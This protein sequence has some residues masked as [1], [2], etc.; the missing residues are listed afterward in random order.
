MHHLLL[1]LKNRA[2]AFFQLKPR[3]SRI[4]WLVTLTYCA[5]Y[6]S[7]PYT[8]GV[9]TNFAGW[10]TWIDQGEYLKASLAFANVDFLPQNFFYPP[11][12]PA[13]GSIFLPLSK[14]H[15]YFVINLVC[16]L[17]FSYTFIRLADCYLS[18]WSSVIILFIS[19]IFDFRIFENFTIPW[20]TT[21]NA[22]LLSTAILGL[23]WL[24]EI[25]QGKRS[26]LKSWEVFFVSTSLG[27]LVPTRPV[28]AP[29]GLILGLAFLMGYWKIFLS[30][31]NKV[32]SPFKFLLI[33]ISGAL[34]GPIIFIAFNYLVFGNPLGSYIQVANGAGIFPLDFFEKFISIWLDGKTLYGDSPTSLTENIPWLL[35]SIA[36]YLWVLFNG[37]FLLRTIAVAIAAM[38]FVYL[39][40]GDLL[41]TGIWRF[42]NIHYFKWILPYLGLFA[43]LLIQQIING[44]KHRRGWVLPT[45]TLL[46]SCLMTLSIQLSLETKTIT[47]TLTNRSIEFEIPSGEV[48]Y[49][50]IK[51]IF[52]GFDTIYF[53][54][55]KAFIDGKELKP[56][57]EF[58]LLPQ[59][60]DVRVLFIRPVSGKSLE[61]TPDQRMTIHQSAL[62]AEAGNYHFKLG[63]LKPLREDARPHLAAPYRI[64]ETIDFSNNRE[65]LFYA[66]EGFSDPE[67]YGRWSL[68]NRAVIR[69]HLSNLN[70]QKKIKLEMF[71]RSLIGISQPC[72]RIIVKA[73][74][75]RIG[76]ELL[77]AKND[78][79]EFLVHTYTIPANLITQDR[80][81][82]I[83]V[84]TPN[85]VTPKALKINEDF[86]QLGIN[87]K[88]L[89]LSQ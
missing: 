31:P 57:R 68:N 81:L 11:L 55:H 21:L 59:G 20:T 49:I 50:D 35:I 4:L 77:C 40:Y 17:W 29:V 43:W 46:L 32:P 79:N 22:A 24:R 65:G 70:P 9:L 83:L 89:T 12:Y 5:V 41:P 28:D 38:L 18:R 7:S 75:S 15:P 56:I 54:N 72:Q 58:R 8:P 61:F 6:F 87:L 51:G 26:R 25:I 30:S 60:S 48:D 33:G 16:L 76:T 62:L 45:T 3:I 52:G 69:M 64:G 23:I 27:L 53:G 42:L 1:Q 14:T 13:L 80:D 10:W 47:S 19:T 82:E 73:N 37:D 2:H 74:N 71:Y 44:L 86:R 36:G 67:A 78:G 88:E 85:S 39:P 63:A 34:I 84:E 66:V